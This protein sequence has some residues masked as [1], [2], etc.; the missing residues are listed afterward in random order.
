[1]SV[2]RIRGTGGIIMDSQTFLELPKAPTKNTSYVVREGMIRYNQG[3]NAFE[4]VIQFDDG[5]VAYRRFANLD[6]NGKLLTSQLPDYITSGSQ[7]VGTY[8]PITDD[9]DPPISQTEYNPLPTPSPTSSGD[10]Y[11]VRG[12]LDAAQKHFVANNPTTETVIFTPTNPS[13]EGNWIQIKYYVGSNPTVPNS[14]MVTSA[15]GRII[16]ASIPAT[17]HAG[18]QDLA[19]DP[20]LT[21]A[22]DSSASQST[23]T[24]LSD[25]D[26]VI[27]TDTKV[28][29]IRNTRVS[30][31]AGSVLFDN[32][33]I[34]SSKR[35]FTTNS[36]T[37]QTAIDSLAIEGLRR[38]GDSMFNDGRVGAGRLGITYG[39]ATAPSMSFNNGIYD[40]VNNPGNDPS[41]WTD[42]NTGIFHPAD[43]AIGFSTGGIERLRIDNTSLKIYQANNATP[44]TTP[45]I[46]LLGT[47]NTNVGL[48]ALNN[49]F[50]FS[51]VN[52]VQVEFRDG[53]SLFNGSITV[54]QN[55]AITGNTSITGTLNVTGKGT[56][57][58]DLS[59]SG[60][61]EFLDNSTIGTSAS[62]TLLVRSTTTFEAPIVFNGTSNRFKN[63]N[64]M[65]AG[66]FTFESVT[67]QSTVELSGSD[68]VYT[69][70]NYAD[71]TIKD[72][73]N[74]RTRLNR[75]GV[76][77][78]VLAVIDN[79]VG[80]D[81]MI[82]YS[83]QRNTV[84]QKSNGA[85]TTVSG[86]G[87]EIPF[88][89]ASWVLSGS[90]YQVTIT[91]SNIQSVQVQELSGSNYSPV[92]V[93][94]IVISPTNAVVQ[95]PA[96]PDYRFNGR[97]IVT[98]K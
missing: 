68:L 30:I 61:T 27:M 3:W 73:A 77:L 51:S 57:S 55:A 82:A 26:W 67:N 98:Y 78:P 18:L 17:G 19:T 29:R 50:M 22:F 63:I 75:Y 91:N 10:Y 85:W 64:L 53:L 94:N 9:I 95:I 86:G 28:Q 70:G 89:T 71:V 32:T 54:S 97:F 72:G 74:I 25:G 48:T 88:T 35:E 6:N 44:A 81:G 15:F 58:S 84:M 59:V 37:V 96:T 2:N 1:M 52:K 33:I 79:A 31:S 43:D 16:T 39:T 41:K 12:L 90:Y 14:K 4:G 40:P 49:S 46:Q 93:D 76:Q 13:G 8:S 36:S 56:F 11:I 7:Y 34:F 24:A 5:S 92:E 38:T 62:N 66:K 80:V 23:E 21:A 20:E 42:S 83:T 60:I 47:G 87:V 45:S 69:M 65:S